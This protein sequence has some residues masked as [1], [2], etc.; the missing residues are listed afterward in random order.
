MSSIRYAFW[1]PFSATCMYSISP[2]EATSG[3]LICRKEPACEVFPLKTDKI[4]VEDSDAGFF[5]R[6][7]TRGAAFD[8]QC[9]IIG[10]ARIFLVGLSSKAECICGGSESTLIQEPNECLRAFS[11]R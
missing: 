11:A 4:V 3:L 1:V 6:E 10:R 8:S 2:P 9:S 7:A 5:A